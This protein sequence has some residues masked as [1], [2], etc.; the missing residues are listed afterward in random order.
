MSEYFSRVLSLK[1]KAIFSMEP[2]LNKKPTY[3]Q[4]YIGIPINLRLP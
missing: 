3:E 4:F 2:L 1:G